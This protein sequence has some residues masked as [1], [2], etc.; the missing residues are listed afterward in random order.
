MGRMRNC[1]FCGNEVSDGF[2]YLM[3]VNT[4]N[5]WN[6]HHACPHIGAEVEVVVTIY[7]DSEEEVIEK[8]NGVYEK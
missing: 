4:I 5:Q 7:G 2:P 8:W 1:P 6:Y 3:Y